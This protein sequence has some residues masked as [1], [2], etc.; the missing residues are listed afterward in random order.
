MTRPLTPPTANTTPADHPVSNELHALYRE[1]STV[2]PGPL[3]DRRILAAAKA[4]LTSD[5]RRSRP[6]RSWWKV[7]LVPVATVA[8]GVLGV[9]L[10]WRVVDQQERELRAAMSVVETQ[11]TAPEAP[12][13]AVTAPAPSDATAVPPPLPTVEAPVTPR[14]PVI[15][16]SKPS[17]SEA[18]IAGQPVPAEAPKAFPQQE[19]QLKAEALASEPERQAARA[20]SV[21]P[22]TDAA[23]KKRGADAIMDEAPEADASGASGLA[24]S[25]PASVSPMPVARP[26][27]DNRLAEKE[28]RAKTEVS[29]HVDDA[30]TPEDWLKH[31]RQLREAG[32]DA[33]A[34]QSLARFRL[35]YPDHVVPGDL[36]QTK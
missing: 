25:A 7:L 32:R 20:P 26:S 16:A 13:G 5:L 23:L 18:K 17:R 24:G 10:A 6:S 33:D 12:V 30:A 19:N 4:E 8:I 22:R 35:R 31:I 15:E 28:G 34:A 27:Y 36:I 3:L 21:S 11:P 14:S 1:G 29:A 9:S 2:E